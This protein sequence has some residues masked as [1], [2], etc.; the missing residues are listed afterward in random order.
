MMKLANL[1]TQL[2]E[3]SLIAITV[4]NNKV[5]I[6]IGGSSRADKMVKTLSKFQK[7]KHFTKFV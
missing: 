5:N 2:S 7:L 6:R 1:L 4:K 3:N